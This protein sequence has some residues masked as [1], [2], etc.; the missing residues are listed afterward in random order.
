MKDEETSIAINRSLTEDLD[1]IRHW[2]YIE[3]QIKNE[4]NRVLKANGLNR[5]TFSELETQAIE[6]MNLE[7]IVSTEFG[8]VCKHYQYDENGVSLYCD[9]LILTTKQQ[10]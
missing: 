4:V 3:S 2:A 7:A 10:E 9:R 6:A 1:P 8:V 5:S